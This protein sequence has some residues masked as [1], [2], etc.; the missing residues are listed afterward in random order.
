[1]IAEDGISNKL[2]NL[3]L[4]V[5]IIGA[6][7]AGYLLWGHLSGGEAGCFIVSG[8]DVVL[9]SSYSKVAGIPVAL[10]GFLFYLIIFLGFFSYNFK[11]DTNL[12]KLLSL[13]TIVGLLASLWF[14]YLQIFVIKAFCS[15]CLISLITSTLLFIMGMYVL[16]GNER[17]S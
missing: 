8:C 10:G 1:M 11:R 13:F 17:E 3:F 4:L 15:Y 14:L 12:L 5:A 2:I 16:K 6:I 9:K 7:D